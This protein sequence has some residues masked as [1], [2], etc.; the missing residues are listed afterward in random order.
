MEYRIPKPLIVLIG[1][2]KYED[3]TNISDLPNIY[4]N[5][6]L[7][8]NF[9]SRDPLYKG[10]S[11]TDVRILTDKNSWEVH[12]EIAR[13][14]EQLQP[15][16]RIFIYYTGHG[17]YSKK[18]AKYFLAS[19]DSEVDIVDST[20]IDIEKI[21]LPLKTSRAREKILIV[22]ACYSGKIH[23][24]LANDEAQIIS[25]VV[26]PA[27]GIFAVSSTNSTQTAKF[28]PN[29][30][31]SPTYFTQYLLDALESGINEDRELLTFNDIFAQV[32]YSLSS[33]G[34]SRPVKTIKGDAEKIIF[35][36]NSYYVSKIK[37]EEQERI[38]AEEKKQAEEAEKRRS[39]E[40]EEAKRE[41]ERL[42]KELDAK[43][44]RL[45]ELREATVTD[46]KIPQTPDP[47]PNAVAVEISKQNERSK[48]DRGKELHKKAMINLNSKNY[49][50]AKKLFEELLALYP[51][52]Y[53][54]LQKIAECNKGMN[55][56]GQDF[57]D[58]IIG[59]LK[60]PLGII[61]SVVFLIVIISIA[62]PR[63]DEPKK[64]IDKPVT[65]EPVSND[66]RDK[67]T[68]K[69]M[70]RDSSVTLTTSPGYSLVSYKIF[71]FLNVEVFSDADP[72]KVDG[73][74]AFVNIFWPGIDT[75][76]QFLADGLYRYEI[77]SKNNLNDQP[78]Q[79]SGFV[80]ISRAE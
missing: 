5:I 7:L 46:P 35:C 6:E 52:N 17:L 20:S 9:F 58:F 70:N 51:G 19:R 4:F 14:C 72:Y 18:T 12:K 55:A 31:N 40:L 10:I 38:A 23:E 41:E 80:L 27:S 54:T 36:A 42:L 60:S 77:E 56:A 53:F 78:R 49:G 13:L 71:N 11:E 22:D 68:L 44:L 39:E 16:S 25:Q 34:L 26:E 69:L 28:D 43:R 59:K 37:A 57:D 2:G 74:Q 30:P 50:E 73:E 66:V 32:D 65:T 75:N 61:L 33:K 62:S 8:K 45:Q 48:E 79:K 3:N 1:N 63:S 47:T 67:D 29:N 76:K 15:G 21:I 64:E 24:N